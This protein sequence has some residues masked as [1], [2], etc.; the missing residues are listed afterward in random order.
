MFNFLL[1]TLSYK[2][3]CEQRDW[4]KNN[5]FLREEA[6]PWYKRA[7]I[8][9]SKY[10]L[11]V[12]SL[13][14]SVFLLLSA[15]SWSYHELFTLEGKF[16]TDLYPIDG[17]V[18][19]NVT[20][21]GAVDINDLPSNTLSHEFHSCSTSYHLEVNEERNDL[22]AEVCIREDCNH[23]KQVN[24]SRKNGHNSE[25][26]TDKCVL[27][28]QPSLR[29][30]CNRDTTQDIGTQALVQSEQQLFRSESR[31]TPTIH[32]LSQRPGLDQDFFSI[33]TVQATIAAIVYPIVIGF[34]SLLLQRRH[35]AKVSLQI[36][37]DISAAILTG[38][39]ALFL[40]MA[41]GVQFLFLSKID[42]TV[43]FYWL[44]LD[45]IWFLFNIAGVI[46]FLYQ[47]FK[48]LQPELRANIQRAYVINF[49][50]PKEMRRNLENFRFHNAISYGW[51]P[52]PSYEDVE[53]NSIS[54]IIIS[55]FGRD[56]GTPQVTEPKKENW[57]IRDVRFR[58]LSRAIFSWQRRQ[59]NTL[60]DNQQE[61]GLFI[62]PSSP[63]TEYKSENGL[64]RI[65]G[66]TDLNWWEKWLIRRA[67]VLSPKKKTTAPLKIIEI[68]NGLVSEVLITTETSEEVAFR[69]AL[70]ELVNLHVA[71]IN[72]GTFVTDEGQ[73]E[74]YSNL[75]S[76]DHI[77]RARLYDVW[78]GEYRRLFKITTKLLSEND[79]Y[80]NQMMYVPNLLVSSL[81]AVR[82]IEIPCNFLQL[83]L[84]MHHRLN[85]WWSKNAEEQGK[86]NHDPCEPAV[87][88]APAFPI[89]DKAINGYIGAWE[90]LKNECF[91]PT[92]DEA[93]SWKQYGEISELYV[94]HLNG[95]L[96]MLFDSLSLGNT[97]GSEWLCDS[98]IKWWSTN[99]IRFSASRSF[100]LDERRLTV[101]VFR[102]QWETAGKLSDIFMANI[103]EGNA[104]KSLWVTCLRNYWID[105]CCIS[106]YS[107]I[108]LGKDCE[109][110]KSLPA[111]LV[112]CLGKGEPLREGG[113]SIGEEWMIQ[114]PEDLL[115]AI[116]RQYHIDGSYM[117]G[118]RG[119]LD[120]VVD[121]I[122]RHKYQAM[123]P[124]RVYSN[125]HMDDL[126]SLSDGQLIYLCLL[127]KESWEL[128]P[129]LKETIQKYCGNDD[130]AFRGFIKQIEK[131]KDRLNNADFLKYESL[132]SCITSKSG[133]KL[134]FKKSI[135]SLTHG[136]TQLIHGFN[137]TRDEQLR[138]MAISNNRLQEI[139]R[140][141][142]DSGFRKETGKV[143]ISLFSNVL[144]SK[145]EHTGYSLKLVNME[146]GRFVDP[147][148]EQLA[149]NEA[150]WFNDFVGSQVA[151][152]VMDEI[153]NSLDQITVDIDGPLAYWNKIKSAASSIRKNRKSPIL[154][155]SSRVEP[156]WLLDWR[157][158]TY[159]ENTEKPNDLR[160]LR[161]RQ[162]KIDEYVFNLN[163]IPVFVAPIATGS[164]YLIPMEA[165]NSLEFTEIEDQLFIKVDAEPNQENDMLVN[166]IMAWNFQLDITPEECW[167][168]RYTK[169]TN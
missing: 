108:Q 167:K 136:F 61:P 75:E 74:N 107:M 141:S 135:A 87:L 122:S 138:S 71:L 111:T 63:G 53:S 35:T 38:L 110:E 109:C 105:L 92:Q 48:Y 3:S 8:H 64:C 82:P 86:T 55:E 52:G 168:L 98:L 11:R 31:L 46:W 13:L 101:E 106:V 37:L 114:T 50:W 95:T 91:P 96:N 132:Y 148:M 27:A 159:D 24:D 146:K 60:R 58:L 94:R 129:G 18:Q 88:H 39:S 30:E 116:F 2:L 163:D 140:W 29:E 90:S 93:L 130:E 7:L 21:E 112:S 5:T 153:L 15:V 119:R 36:Y 81:G 42:T 72:S 59:Q 28:N 126:D 131:W 139:A 147:P 166:L 49:I 57:V 143:P 67:F 23:L 34:V 26:A 45:G 1:A 144:H 124:G 19:C 68:L 10:P 44:V 161:D 17:S 73:L 6:W 33:W 14:F 157:R 56:R 32:V 103:D 120:S 16:N 4:R 128:T 125:R 22:P 102:Q 113:N 104:Q 97:S 117:Q 127:V 156:H 115:I 149:I 158:S 142:S 118:Y 133:V 51:L 137:L 84:F 77:F 85:L 152:T 169:E 164:S 12:S 47:T 145:V 62:L 43:L 160:L 76:R 155:I 134:P 154:L 165:L 40:V 20:R 79:A 65:E 99:S 89:Y 54:A 9:A 78:T 41:M 123:V 69:D 66:S 121:S 151:I 150:E 70:N 162:F 80:F 83:S 100:I 25:N